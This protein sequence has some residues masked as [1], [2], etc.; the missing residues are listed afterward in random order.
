MI[1]QSGQPKYW[2]PLCRRPP[3]IRM[4]SHKGHGRLIPFLSLSLST[5]VPRPVPTGQPMPIPV[6]SIFRAVLLAMFIYK[7]NERNGAGWHERRPP[8][9]RA[10]YYRWSVDVKS[11]HTFFRLCCYYFDNVF[12]F[13]NF[14]W[15]R[16]FDYVPTHK[17]HS[18]VSTCAQPC[19]NNILKCFDISSGQITRSIAIIL[20]N[21]L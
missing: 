9:P 1:Y 14:Q 11:A 3:C 13:F 12:F 4:E 10:N 16:Q 20:D 21:N 19:P 15:C 18:L 2:A 7:A 17:R 5:I 6:A 8:D